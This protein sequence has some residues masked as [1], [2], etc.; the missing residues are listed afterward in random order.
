M[1][2]ARVLIR[3]NLVDAVL[4]NQKSFSASPSAFTSK[5]P[6]SPTAPQNPMKWHSQ[7]S[8]YLLS[9]SSQS[10]TKPSA[11]RGK[12]QQ[13]QFVVNYVK[14]KGMI[15]IDQVAEEVKL[16]YNQLGIDDM[17]FEQEVAETIGDNVSL[18]FS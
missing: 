1:L 16:F 2:L 7:L 10:S 11:F 9:R 3:R 17:Y 13:M 6:S 12:D 8:N 14:T 15:P 18:S 5:S 4:K